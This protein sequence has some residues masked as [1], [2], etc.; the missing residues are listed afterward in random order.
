MTR[1]NLEVT[2]SLAE[3]SKCNLGIAIPSF[4][5]RFLYLLTMAT[6]EKEYLNRLKES[7]ISDIKKWEECS[8]QFPDRLEPVEATIS[9]LEQ[10]VVY[11]NQKIVET[12]PS[13]NS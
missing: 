8:D 4:S 1:I 12:D 9:L 11:L 13:P 5:L 2:E 6:Q 3:L 7:C 10:V